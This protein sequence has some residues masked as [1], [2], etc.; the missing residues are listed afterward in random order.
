LPGTPERHAERLIRQ[1]GLCCS[2]GPPAVAGM[3]RKRRA[4][5]LP[6]TLR[7]CPRLTGPDLDKLYRACLDPSRG[8][9]RLTTFGG[10][11]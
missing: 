6:E 4:G 10:I 1:P 3:S 7:A 8:A 2:R 5:S 9:R 11:S